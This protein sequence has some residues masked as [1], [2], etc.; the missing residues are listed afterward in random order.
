MRH[1]LEIRQNIH[2]AITLPDSLVV[3]HSFLIFLAA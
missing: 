1:K 2:E 3:C